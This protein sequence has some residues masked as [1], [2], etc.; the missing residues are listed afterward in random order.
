MP[1]AYNISYL[2]LC[3]QIGLDEKQD[4]NAVGFLANPIVLICKFCKIFGAE[5]DRLAAGKPIIVKLAKSC[6]MLL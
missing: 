2:V 4:T 1:W 5:T 3:V 6:N